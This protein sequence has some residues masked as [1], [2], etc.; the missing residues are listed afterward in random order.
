MKS[1]GYESIAEFYDYF[2]GDSKKEI[3]FVKNILR[4]YHGKAKSLLELGCGT[5]NN[6]A[7]LTDKYEVSGVDNSPAMLKIAKE[8]VSSAKLFQGDI[9]DFS[10]TGQYDAVI[11]LYD[12]INHLTL[13]SNWKNLIKNTFYNLRDEGL[14][15]FDINTLYK[16]DMFCGISPVINSKG[17][18]YLIADV[19]KVSTYTYLW[20]LKIFE[21]KRKNIYKLYEANIKESSF[22]IWRILNELNRY[23]NVLKVTDENSLKIK[24]DTQRA[25]FVC[26]KKVNY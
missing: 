16:L 17:K 5:G 15:I 14:F 26:R 19:V 9:K 7:E 12:T 24:H 10:H 3:S 4:K 25:Y 13:F 23:F 21:C 20:K 6:L 22:D 2:T 8:K 1:E 11:C 18:N